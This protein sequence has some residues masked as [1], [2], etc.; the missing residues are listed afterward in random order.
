MDIS[1]GAGAAASSSTSR[2][3]FGQL[4][5]NLCALCGE[6]IATTKDHIPPQGI[7]PKPRDNDI[8]FNTVPAC[9]ECNNG[10]AV[11][12]EEFKILIGLSTGEFHKNPEIVVDSIARTIGKNQRIA[13]QI[14]STKRNVH[15][16]LRGPILEPAVAVQFDGKKYTKVISR[17]VR[18]LFWQHK[19][20]A[21]GLS[22][23]ITVFPTNK[24][25]PDFARSWMDLMNDR[26]VHSLN[27]ETF[28][29][30][31]YF[32]NNGTSFWMMQ[33]FRKH[34]VFA[35]AESP[36]NKIKTKDSFS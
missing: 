17:I 21:L 31:F 18:G 10:S 1:G 24:I 5:A 36:E 19:G 4:M 8:N 16:Y 11:E 6:N 14:F 25:T 12:D 13:N 34:T 32:D 26:V 9:S 33:F 29:Y 27:K 2:Y 22:T 23:K 30:K 28:I 35:Y 7:Y 15:A 3:N 20:H